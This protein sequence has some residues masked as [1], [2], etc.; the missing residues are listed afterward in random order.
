MRASSSGGTHHL[1]PA[2]V[3]RRICRVDVTAGRDDCTAV[4]DL[5]LGWNGPPPVQ[6]ESH[7]GGS[8]VPRETML[9]PPKP[10]AEAGPTNFF[11]L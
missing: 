4:F 2:P 5:K 10:T 6:A 11:F 8:S 9:S 7:R 1:T 3:G